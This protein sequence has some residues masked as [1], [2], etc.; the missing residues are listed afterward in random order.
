MERTGEP[1]LTHQERPV[2]TWN[3]FLALAVGLVAIAFALWQLVH[4]VQAAGQYGPFG[5]LGSLAWAVLLFLVGALVLAGHVHAAAQ[6]GGDPAA[7]RQLSRHHAHRR[8][9]R[10]QPVLH[11][12]QDLAARAQPQRRATQGQ[13][14][15]RQSDRDRCRRGMAGRRH[16]ARRVS[17]STTTRTTSSCRAK[18][19]SATW[20]RRSPTITATDARRRARTDAAR[21]RRDR[22]ARAGDRIAGSASARPAWPSRK[23]G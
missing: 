10:L 4:A 15:A 21:Q 22:V 23:R 19:R 17:M 16:R 13:R 11:A 20:P 2:T 18:P 14:Q 9:A 1:K 12:T 3:G 8:T 5:I 7:L 6:R